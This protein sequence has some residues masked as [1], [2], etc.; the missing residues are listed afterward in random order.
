MWT[1]SPICQFGADNS[2]V[3]NYVSSLRKALLRNL[4]TESSKIVDLGYQGQWRYGSTSLAE[5]AYLT[6]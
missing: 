3:D 1:I 2:N 6:F 5:R 4:I